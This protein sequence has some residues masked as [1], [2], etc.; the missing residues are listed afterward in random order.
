MRSEAEWS[1]AKQRKES[2]GALVVTER[3]TQDAGESAGVARKLCAAVLSR[4]DPIRAE[5]RPIKRIRVA[6]DRLDSTRQP[7]V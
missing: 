6:V 5:R 7:S 3:R 4:S 2:S 1:G